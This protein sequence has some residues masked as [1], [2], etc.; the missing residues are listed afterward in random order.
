M[1]IAKTLGLTIMAVLAL[2]M[3]ASAGASA[4]LPEA[5]VNV[6]GNTF[7]ATSG[8]GELTAGELKIKCTSDTGSG[9]V[10]GAKTLTAEVHF[11]KCSILGLPA[12]SLGDAA[13]TILVTGLDGE[14]CYIKKAAPVEVGVFFTLLTPV[15]IE[16]PSLGELVIVT[17]SV[18]GK[19]T[20]INS[21]KTGPYTLEFPKTPLQ[22]EGKT[23]KLSA[24]Q[25][26]G[27][28]KAAT[29]VTTETVTFAKAIEIMG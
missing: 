15:H 19:L 27:A 17:G 12:N 2:S 25:N 14:L 23:A 22:C 5:L 24:S 13:E 28:A 6:A 29:E 21:S 20:P 4:A 16:I 26:E 7:T 8:A 9:S 11:A 1:R 10:T 3:I 18:V